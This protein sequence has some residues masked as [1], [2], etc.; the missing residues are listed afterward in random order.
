MTWLFLFAKLLPGGFKLLEK[1][2]DKNSALS[3]RVAVVQIA[4][5]C[6]L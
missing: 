6:K 1:K 5:H 2:Q 4:S 3:N